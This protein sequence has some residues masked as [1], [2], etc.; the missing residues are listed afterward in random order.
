MLRIFVLV[1]LLPSVYMDKFYCLFMHGS[2]NIPTSVGVKDASSDI[3]KNYWTKI[4]E[5]VAPYCDPIMYTDFET[6]NHAWNETDLIKQYCDA[7]VPARIVF[8]HSFGNLVVAA[9]VAQ[10]ITGCAKLKSADDKDATFWYSVQGPFR[11]SPA[12]DVL[13][14]ECVV[15]E[16]KL[17]KYV[18]DDT[19][20]A[21]T[22]PFKMKKAY[23]SMGPHW[24]SKG[25]DDKPNLVQSNDLAC[26]GDDGKPIA[27]CQTLAEVAKSH[28]KGQMCGFQP[29]G[30][31]A[32]TAAKLM[33]AAALVGDKWGVDKEDKYP[34]HGN[35][36]LVNFESC[37]MS[38][39]SYGQEPTF[40]MYA[41]N[42]NHKMGTCSSKDDSDKTKQPC[43]W[44]AE[45]C[46]RSVGVFTT[47]KTP[48]PVP[49][50]PEV[51]QSID[52]TAQVAEPK[53]D[54]VLL[55]TQAKS[56]PPSKATLLKR[57]R[58]ARQ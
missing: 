35:D 16:S 24:I 15:K 23:G 27:D 44:Y 8:T 6:V 3:A 29:G 26:I 37:R 22:T 12:A 43:A 18:L 39:T 17:A 11:G 41:M 2:G 53:V 58:A 13:E 48:D 50:K 49:A 7:I 33:A 20:D 5:T 42:G 31:I 30:E 14:S 46:S 36:G 47:E 10:G 40:P 55:V 25:L 28:M 4:A 19:C 52:P 45:M 9:G 21:T 1:A 51:L 54:Q 34:D 32:I 57:M 56:A 38:G